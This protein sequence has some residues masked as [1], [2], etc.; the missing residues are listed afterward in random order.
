MNLLANFYL[1]LR[2]LQQFIALSY[3][4]LVLVDGVFSLPFPF[5][6]PLIYN[7]QNIFQFYTS[8][9]SWGKRGAG[10]HKSNVCTAFQS[11]APD[12]NQGFR[13]LEPVTGH[14]ARRATTPAWHYGH[15]ELAVTPQ[16]GL[17]KVMVTKKWN[18]A[19]WQHSTISRKK[20]TC[21]SQPSTVTYMDWIPLP[22]QSF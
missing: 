10:G 8:T 15:P 9:P 21:C 5:T 14:A 13:T 11:W 22:T 3:S 19:A 16:R 12:L 17:R 20:W 7:L 6:S 1:S 18:S 2:P 4:I